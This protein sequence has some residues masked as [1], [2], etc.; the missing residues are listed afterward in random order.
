VEI[1]NQTISVHTPPREITESLIDEY[2]KWYG[3]RQNEAIQ[4]IRDDIKE[5]KIKTGLRLRWPSLKNS[6]HD[7]N[8]SG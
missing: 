3:I 2:K 1:N 7:V 6:P 4:R 8:P 5:F